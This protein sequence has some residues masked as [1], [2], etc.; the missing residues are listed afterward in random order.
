MSET[1]I[2]IVPVIMIE[3]NSRITAQELLD[4]MRDSVVSDNI[5]VNGERR[6]RIRWQLMGRRVTRTQASLMSSPP[7]ASLIATPYEEKNQLK[8]FFE[9]EHDVE[10]YLQEKLSTSE[11]IISCA[12]TMEPLT[13]WTNIMVTSCGHLF[14]KYALAEWFSTKHNCPMC[15]SVCTAEL[16]KCPFYMT[17]NLPKV[18]LPPHPPPPTHTLPKKSRKMDACNPSQI[19]DLMTLISIN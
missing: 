14:D 12:I 9:H 2:A 1:R 7:L 5:G 16:R 18:S 4:E 3:I 17:I 13:D 15:R 19:H 11:P 6:G 8:I 10:Y